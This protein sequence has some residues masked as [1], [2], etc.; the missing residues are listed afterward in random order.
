M[1]ISQVYGAGGN[2]GATY[3]RDF[4]EIF[5]AGFTTI[6]ISNWSIQY[7]SAGGPTAPGDWA[8]AVIPASTNITPGTYFLI[9]LAGGGAAGIALPTPDYL[10]NGINISNTAGKIALVTSS[11]PLNGVAA[12]N[13]P[14]V[15]D[16]LGYGLGAS[17]FETELLSTT[18]TDNTKSILRFTGGCLD[19]NN[20]SNDFT[21]GA[22]NP[23]NSHSPI[24]PCN[25]GIPFLSTSSV[26]T[27]TAIGGVG[28]GEQNISLAGSS[29]TGFPGNITITASAGVE[30]SLTSGS[31]YT[32]PGTNYTA[33]DFEYNGSN[34]SANYYAFTNNPE[35][36]T[37][38]G[39]SSVLQQVNF[40]M[41]N[42][43]LYMGSGV[44][45][46]TP[47]ITVK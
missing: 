12:C 34:A 32:I 19:G 5:N 45:N 14:Y 46:R 9:A 39:S 27:L 42:A 21:I 35:N 10:F 15:T 1:V 40:E 28:S 2:P 41:R 37:T 3:N 25:V 31:G 16:I 18:G 22:V 13:N 43:P 29:L 6:D 24:N 44:S 8:V 20:N 33:T 7:A 4:V 23:R 36:G 26:G 47:V 38:T 11:V 17:C 30:I